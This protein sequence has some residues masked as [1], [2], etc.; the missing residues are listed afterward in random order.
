[1]EQKFDNR[2]LFDLETPDFEDLELIP[3]SPQYFKIII[4]NNIIFSL[5]L[6]AGFSVAYFFLHERFLS[7]Q[8]WLVLAVI[9]V[10][11]GFLFLNSVMGF[12]Y[13]K[14][15]VRENDLIYQYGW[16]KR[17][18][19]IVPFNRIQHIKVEQG[20]LSKILKLKS[21]SVFTAGIDT[22]DVA[23]KG[24]PEEIAEGINHV[25]LKHIKA[26]NGENGAGA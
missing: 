9:I 19:I 25:I 1:M 17:S 2:Q 14:Y 10:L 12:Q 24:L 16:L 26:E 11:I 20:W 22:G 13:R 4:L 6:L 18:L 7:F 8:I 5:F 3:V 15:A 21:L 23:V